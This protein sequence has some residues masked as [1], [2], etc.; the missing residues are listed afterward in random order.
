MLKKLE[1]CNKIWKKV[2]ITINKE[3][4][5]DPVYNKKHLK[6]KIKP[7][8]GKIITNFHSN[9]IPKEGFQCIC[10]SVILILEQVRIVILKYF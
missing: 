3:F 4:D 7:Y 10:L 9:K 1:K 2:K 6:A 8:N 5:N